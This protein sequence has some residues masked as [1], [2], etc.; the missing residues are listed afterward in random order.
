MASNDLPTPSDHAG[1]MLALVEAAASEL[2][3]ALAAQIVR[4]TPSL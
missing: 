3:G 1:S 4:A 2:R